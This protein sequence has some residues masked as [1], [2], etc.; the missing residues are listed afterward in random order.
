[1]PEK[2][3]LKNEERNTSS[4]MKQSNTIYL[5]QGFIMKD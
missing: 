2:Q 4:K 3:S 5:E 1:M